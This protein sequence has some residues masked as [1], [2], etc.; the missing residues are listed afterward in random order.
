[1]KILKSWTLKRKPIKIK[2]YPRQCENPK[3]GK[4]I[5]EGWTNECDNFCDSCFDNCEEWKK[6]SKQEWEMYEKDNSYNPSIYRTAWNFELFDEFGYD[7][8]GK[9]YRLNPYN[10]HHYELVD[11]D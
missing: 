11:G 9:K 1:M 6:E 4:G 2:L 8:N 3:C 5:N 10:K 7:K